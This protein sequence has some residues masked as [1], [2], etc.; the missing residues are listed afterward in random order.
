MGMSTERFGKDK[1]QKRSVDY[2]LV[3]MKTEA[4]EGRGHQ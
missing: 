3:R 2:G 1:P 4:D